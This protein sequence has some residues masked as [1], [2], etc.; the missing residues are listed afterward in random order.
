[1]KEYNCNECGKKFSQKCHWVNHTQN[2]KYPCIKIN[3][4]S[5]NN[6]SNNL[7]KSIIETST[8][9]SNINNKHEL[10]KKKVYCKYCLKEFLYTKNLN[11]H[12]REERC[13]V[14]QRGHF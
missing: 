4:I 1:M 13:E 9:V 5:S 12:I 7:T 2:K 11:K 10:D 8:N 3:N 6:S 14:L